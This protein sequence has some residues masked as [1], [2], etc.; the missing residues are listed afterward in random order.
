M[1]SV[2]RR[3]VVPIYNVQIDTSFMFASRY[4]GNMSE[5]YDDDDDDD[6]DIE[7][8]SHCNNKLHCDSNQLRKSCHGNAAFPIP[9][10]ERL[11][12]TKS[13]KPGS[14]RLWKHP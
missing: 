11:S 1:L 10:A 4:L 12:P 14:P 2:D 5:I 13:L 3:F 6:N 9:V 8:T 7:H